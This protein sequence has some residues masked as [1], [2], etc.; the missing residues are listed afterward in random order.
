MWLIWYYHYRP[1]R[2]CGKVMFS[3]ACVKNSVH[4]GRVSAS[5]HAGIHPL[6]GSHPPGRHP[7]GQTPPAPGR[8]RP[9]G[10]CDGRYASYWN[11]FLFL[12]DFSHQA[13]LRAKSD[14]ISNIETDIQEMLHNRSVWTDPQAMFKLTVNCAKI[15][16]TIDTVLN[17]D[18]DVGVDAQ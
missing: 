5:M 16:V 2:S 11:A 12:C 13:K 15:N 7:T 4:R 8:H 1:Q 6:P 10:H 14:I 3:Q 17:F 9:G 18:I